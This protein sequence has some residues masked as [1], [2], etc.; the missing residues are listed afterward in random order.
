MVYCFCNALRERDI[1]GAV[2]AGASTVEELFEKVGCEPRC[3][4]CVPEIGELVENRKLHA[5]QRAGDSLTRA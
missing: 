3:A 2:D 5:R 1:N 4:T